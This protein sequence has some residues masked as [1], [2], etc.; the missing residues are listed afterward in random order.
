VP[1]CYLTILVCYVSVYASS[2]MYCEGI[3][4]VTISRVARSLG[5]LLLDN[6]SALPWILA[7][8]AIAILTHM[9][10]TVSSMI[11]LYF[12]ARDTGLTSISSLFNEKDLVLGIITRVI[13]LSWLLDV[14]LAVILIL[15]SCKVKTVYAVVAQSTQ[16]GSIVYYS[17]GLCFLHASRRTVCSQTTTMSS[18]RF[19]DSYIRSST[20]VNYTPTGSVESIPPTRS[21][22]T[23]MNTFDIRYCSRSCSSLGVKPHYDISSPYA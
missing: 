14:V 15:F 2:R 19:N 7:T 11:W 21:A 12:S 22:S 18:V 8:Y 23:D 17:G 20:M 1:V 5:G 4:G 13:C 6:S 10:V 16:L 9:F 3:V